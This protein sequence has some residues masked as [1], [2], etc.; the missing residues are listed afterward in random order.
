L[1]TL[2][3]IE[4]LLAGRIDRQGAPR[5][6]RESFSPHLTL[7]RLR[8]PVPRVKVAHLGHIQSSAGPSRIDRVTLYESRLSPRGPTYVPLAAALLQP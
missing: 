6:S 5:A 8:E 1:D 4:Q 3:R 7:A 2:R